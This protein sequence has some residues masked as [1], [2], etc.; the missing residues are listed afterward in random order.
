MKALNALAYGVAFL[1]A[2]GEIA[3]FWG[4]ERFVPMA[5]DELAVAGALAWAGWRSARDGALW[6]LASWGALCGLVLVLLV[7]TLDHQMH[8]PA[9]AAGPVYLVALSLMLVIGLWAVGRALRLVRHEG[10]R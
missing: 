3:R 1:I 6:H 10:G 2:A 9:K 7:E 4:S 5:L 8:G